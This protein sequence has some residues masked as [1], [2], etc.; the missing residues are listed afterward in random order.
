MT[1]IRRVAGDAAGRSRATAYDGLVWA[2]ATAR[3]RTI[4]D[5][6]RQALADIDGALAACGTDK[7]R[8][9]TA[10]VYLTEMA[11]KAEMDRVWNAWIGPDPAHWPQR[12]CVGAALAGDT[13]VEIVVTAA[14]ADGAERDSS[15]QRD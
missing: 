7:T 8:L 6:T 9:L 13:L 10:T 1:A 11:N 4:A 5:Q 15:R 3:G 12:A 14:Q 2:V